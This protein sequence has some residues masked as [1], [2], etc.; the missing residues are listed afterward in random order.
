MLGINTHLFLSLH[1]TGVLRNILLVSCF[2]FFFWFIEATPTRPRCKHSISRS[3][4]NSKFQSWVIRCILTLN[5]VNGNIFCYK[6]MAVLA[7]CFWTMHTIFWWNT[8]SLEENKQFLLHVLIL[9]GINSTSHMGYEWEYIN[10]NCIHAK[11]KWPKLEY[12]VMTAVHKYCS[13]TSLVTLGTNA[14][15]VQDSML[16]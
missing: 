9:V 11:Q 16:D 10:K 7:S 13:W 6:K 1:G 4:G 12:V 5:R 2:L 15:S 3:I 14:C 8:N